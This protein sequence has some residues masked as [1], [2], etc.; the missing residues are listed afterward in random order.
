MTQRAG[1][2]IWGVQLLC[3]CYPVVIQRIDDVLPLVLSTALHGGM[4][5]APRHK[6][7]C[8][9]HVLPV[10]LWYNTATPFP[11]GTP[12]GQPQTAN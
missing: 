7:S 5:D 1:D 6:I 10:N 2:S 12:V 9:S 3:L 8:T 11:A 4:F